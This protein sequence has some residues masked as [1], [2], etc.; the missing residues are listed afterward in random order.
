MWLMTLLP[1][2]HVLFTLFMGVVSG[3]HDMPISAL[4]EPTSVRL[5]AWPLAKFATVSLGGKS[6][7]CIDEEPTSSDYQI[8]GGIERLWPL[9]NEYGLIGQ[10]L[11]LA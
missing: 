1:L 7:G 8:L 4:E 5:S 11:K 9:T 10:H 2:A 3:R 6:E